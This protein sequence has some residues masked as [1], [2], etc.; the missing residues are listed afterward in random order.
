MKAKRAEREE[1]EKVDNTEREKQRRF[2]GKEMAKTREELEKEQ[3]KREAY[4]RR[5]EKE[6]FK[7]ERL[8]LRMELEKDKAERAARGGKLQSRLG[9]EGYK[10][11]AVQYDKEMDDDE[12]TTTTT[13]A[14]A[15]KAAPNAKKIDDYITKISSYRA[16]GDGERCLKTLLAYLKNP[17]EKPDEAK[18]RT[19]KTD[20]KVFKTRVKPF[21]GAK[22]L[23]MACGFQEN[24]GG[25]ALVLADDAPTAIL[26][27]TKSKIEK[28][29]A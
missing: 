27:E 23:L 13:T 20:N 18:F 8:R 26:A 22:Q 29:I 25:T 3:R 9:V 6:D 14:P 15:K 19:I 10:P 4:L 12:D 5:K 16:G 2:M 1:A 11:D 21:I 7:K 17:I 24:E 28:A